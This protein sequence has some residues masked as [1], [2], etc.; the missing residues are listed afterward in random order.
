MT[1][2]RRIKTQKQQ[3]EKE[4]QKSQAFL[5][6]APEGALICQKT[7]HGVKWLQR[8]EPKDLGTSRK[9]IYISQKNKSLAEQLA[10]KKYHKY[11]IQ[12][13]NEELKALNAYLMRF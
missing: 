12:E 4:L 1:L 5:K 6:S 11:K 9:R 2:S 7:L 3:L 10:L 13:I 8:Q